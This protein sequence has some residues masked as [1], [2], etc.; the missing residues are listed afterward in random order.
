MNVLYDTSDITKTSTMITDNAIGK[1][2][3]IG[4][5]FKMVV[6]VV[7]PTWLPDISTVPTSAGSEYPLQGIDDLKSWINPRTWK[8]KK[9]ERKKK[10]RKE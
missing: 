1:R 10:Q 5:S 9:R 7:G 2:H 8:K 3:V 4:Y 6:R